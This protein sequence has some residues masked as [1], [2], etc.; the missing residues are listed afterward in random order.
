MAPIEPQILFNERKKQCKSQLSF[1]YLQK[2]FNTTMLMF[3]EVNGWITGKQNKRIFKEQDYQL[4]SIKL[5]IKLNEQ[6]TNQANEN[7]KKKLSIYG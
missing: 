4:N 3:C 2:I 7:L 6:G 5:S 1:I